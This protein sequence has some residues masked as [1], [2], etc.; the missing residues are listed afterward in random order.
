MISIKNDK[1]IECMREAG[2]ILAY[3]HE[4]IGQ[5]IKP[6]ITTYELSEY[7]FKLI[8]KS[9]CTASFYHLYDFP[10]PFCISLND[11]VVHGIPDKHTYIKEGDIVSVD[12]GV[13]YKGYHSDAARTHIIGNVSTEI[14]DLVER[15]KQSFFE[16]IKFAKDGNYLHDI[17]NAIATYIEPFGYGIV[18]E[19]VGH[20]IGKAVHEDPDVPNF[21]KKNKGPKLKKGMT[22]AVEPMINLGTKDVYY[23]GPDDW[24]CRTKDG[25]YSAHYENTILITDNEP[26]I[27]SLNI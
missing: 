11:I 18:E 4:E 3:V 6:G 15:T 20:G 24:L 7:G 1:E 8:K 9:G 26:E 14:I 23:D 16:G 25:K 2:K 22:L 13:C 10:A 19:M 17:S 27:L 21:R 5:F 12:G